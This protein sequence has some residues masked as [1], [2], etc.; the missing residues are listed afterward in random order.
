MFTILIW[1]LYLWDY[2]TNKNITS[3]F[4]I[5]RL[6]FYVAFVWLTHIIKMLFGIK[7][8]VSKIKEPYKICNDKEY[9]MLKDKHIWINIGMALVGAYIAIVIIINCFKQMNNIIFS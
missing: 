9:S 2:M 8:Y 6:V 4:A 1:V 7:K 5:N 3:D